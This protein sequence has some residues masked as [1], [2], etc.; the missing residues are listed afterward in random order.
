[1]AM[2]YPNTTMPGIPALNGRISY[3]L[4]FGPRV[5]MKGEKRQKQPRRT[6]VNEFP[7]SDYP[8]PL[9]CLPFPFSKPNRINCKYLLWVFKPVIKERKR[10]CFD[11]TVVLPI[12]HKFPYFRLADRASSTKR[13]KYWCGMAMAC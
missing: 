7:I 4:V 8:P 6:Y 2:D 12:L 3:I 9:V 1:M 11:S 13:K 5:V 10:A